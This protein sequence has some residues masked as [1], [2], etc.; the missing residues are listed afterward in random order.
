MALECRAARCGMRIRWIGGD[1]T[2]SGCAYGTA[3]T[4]RPIAH[5]V[6]ETEGESSLCVDAVRVSRRPLE[7]AGVFQ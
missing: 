5:G 7:A 1:Y 3:E 4:R 2:A 6:P